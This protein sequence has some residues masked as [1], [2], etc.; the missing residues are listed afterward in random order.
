M[1]CISAVAP[2]MDMIAYER[3]LTRKMKGFEVTLEDS[4]SFLASRLMLS[5]CRNARTNFRK[6]DISSKNAQLSEAYED[7]AGTNFPRK[8]K[9]DGKEQGPENKRP[10]GGGERWLHKN[11]TDLGAK[12]APYLRIRLDCHSMALAQPFIS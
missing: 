6:R 10:K 11:Q 9:E 7:D 1:T 4:L 2:L 8:K 3:C 5:I 12:N